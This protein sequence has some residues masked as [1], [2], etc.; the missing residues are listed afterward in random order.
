MGLEWLNIYEGAINNAIEKSEAMLGDL[1]A[2]K[3]VIR[4]L[5]RYVG[6]CFAGGGLDY[7][8]ITNSLIACAFEYT[9]DEIQR[10]LK[11][12]DITFYVNCDDSHFF[13]NNTEYFIGDDIITRLRDTIEIE[14][15]K[16]AK[17]GNR[18][19]AEITFSMSGNT[20][21]SDDLTEDLLN[22]ATLHNGYY[23][24]DVLW[25]KV[26]DKNEAKFNNIISSSEITY[27]AYMFEDGNLAY[28]IHLKNGDIDLYG[29]VTDAGM[30]E[31]EFDLK[32][33]LEMAVKAYEEP[34]PIQSKRIIDR[35]WNK[36]NKTIEKD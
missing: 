27:K 34:M 1:G 3:S 10:V 22:A 4:G 14:D 13:I 28:S 31:K 21:S 18:M 15:I 2:S 6:E 35:Y 12:A 9:R 25:D 23:L 20:G 19:A 30:L 5:T 11:G 8:D 36:S 32:E 26:S 7:D 33:K 29:T 17:F 16:T 24:I